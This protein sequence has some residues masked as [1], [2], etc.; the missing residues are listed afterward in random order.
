MKKIIA[1]L[2]LCICMIGAITVEAREEY[3]VP[4]AVVCQYGDMNVL[5]TKGDGTLWA[6]NEAADSHRKL[7]DDVIYVGKGTYEMNFIAIKSDGTL[8]SMNVNNQN[9]FSQSMYD[10]ASSVS[11]SFQDFANFSVTKEGKLYSWGSTG[12]AP[13]ENCMGFS[14]YDGSYIS[15]NNARE[16]LDDVDS[17]YAHT[18][19]IAA[20]KT[21]G[22]LWRWGLGQDLPKKLADGVVSVVEMEPQAIFAVTENNQLALYYYDE[23]AFFNDVMAL[24]VKDADVSGEAMAYIDVEDS[25]WVGYYT[26]GYG[27]TNFGKALNEVKKVM[28]PDIT[29]GKEE[30]KPVFA[31]KKD[32]SLW[33]TAKFNVYEDYTPYSEDFVKLMDNVESVSFSGGDGTIITCDGALYKFNFTDNAEIVT[34]LRKIAQLSDPAPSDWA[35]SE[36][37]Y[38]ISQGLVPANMQKDYKTNISRIEF[39]EILT[40]TIEAKSG[41]SIDDMLSAGAWNPQKDFTDTDSKYVDYM[42]RLGIVNGVSD[43]LFE[44][45][46]KITREEAAIMLM[47]T[48]K[49]LG[50]DT[51]HNSTVEPSVSSWARDGV[52]FVTEK[53]IMNGTGDG[54]DPSGKYTKEQAIAT[55]VRLYKNL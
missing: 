14:G 12:R 51:T 3:K 2:T 29:V 37:Q 31:I 45:Y 40:K 24:D 35:A 25:L 4:S 22:T 7:L 47:R 1:I 8:W 16:I 34:N 32:N 26:E 33:I 18:F 43:T 44:P 30:Y 49:V 54:F 10:V 21:D 48:A 55:F 46:S 9:E 41:K 27:E 20:L 15:A 28:M 36:I 13:E 17:V 5:Y 50:F 6:Y 19:N 39:C 11:T 23:W 38:A 42:C 53:G 52:G